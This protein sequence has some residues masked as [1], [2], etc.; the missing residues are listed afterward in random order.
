MGFDEE[1]AGRQRPHKGESLD[2]IIMPPEVI[3]EN[4]STVIF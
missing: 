4:K 1:E 3:D 2:A